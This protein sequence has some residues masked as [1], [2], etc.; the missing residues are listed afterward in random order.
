[1]PLKNIHQ[2]AQ[3]HRY[4]NK[5]AK[6]SSRKARAIIFSLEAEDKDAILEVENAATSGQNCVNIIKERSNQLYKK[7]KFTE[8]YNA[9]ESLK[10]NRRSLNTS[11]RAFLPKLEKRCYKNKSFG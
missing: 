1:M 11:I 4:W 6:F 7:D 8:Q 3:T 9:L 2:L 5:F 10:T